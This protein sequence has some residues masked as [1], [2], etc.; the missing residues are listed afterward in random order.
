M[1]KRKRISYEDIIEEL[2]YEWDLED[3]EDLI[4]FLSEEYIKIKRFNVPI[5]FLYDLAREHKKSIDEVSEWLEN[6]KTSTLNYWKR[7]K[8]WVY[9]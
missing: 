5:S 1:S 8:E 6:W 4:D 3:E 7:V 9:K 2:L